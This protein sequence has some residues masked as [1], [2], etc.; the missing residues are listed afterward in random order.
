MTFSVHSQPLAQVIAM[1]DMKNKITDFGSF[2]LGSR[3]KALLHALDGG[4]KETYEALDINFEPRW[5]PVVNVLSGEDSKSITQIARLIGQ[6]H[7]AVNQVADR[8]VKAGLVEN[9]AD[10]KDSRV[11]HLH[12]TPRGR[13]TVRQLQPV[14]EGVHRA[15]EKLLTEEAPGFLAAIIKMES[16]L[17]KKSY[18]TRIM[19]CLAKSPKRKIK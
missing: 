5:F 18:H 14:W 17:E 3:I 19:E 12:L 9:H 2:A 10:H 15:A 13:N 7:Q 4:V 6:S 11:R 8:L 16:A 1:P